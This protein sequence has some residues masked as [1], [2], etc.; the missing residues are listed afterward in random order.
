MA[1]P[2]KLNVAL[3]EW[4]TICAALETG[5]QMVL[6]RK[7]GIYEAAGEFELENREFVLFPTY[8]HQNLKML[9][10]EAQVGFEP[11]TA[12]PG[13]IRLASAGVVTDI[14][15]LHSRAQMDTLDAEHVW[16][17]PLIDMRFNYRPEHPLFL[18]LVRA[19][20]LHEPLLIDNTPA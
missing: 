18:L 3:K 7:G 10:P 12:E 16:T 13:Q 8:L 1:F 11:V 6:L 20:R 5:R 2:A 9:K 15:Q 19:Y 4:A 14:L 17:A